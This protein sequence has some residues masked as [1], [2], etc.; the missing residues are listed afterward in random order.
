MIKE[1]KRLEAMKRFQEVLQSD[2][3]NYLANNYLAG[4]YLLQRQWDQAYSHLS[5]MLEKNPDAFETNFLTANFYYYRR[6]YKEALRFG[7]KAFSIQPGDVSSKRMND[8]RS[9]S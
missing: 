6:Q 7:Q 5:R 9:E 2:P 8:A 4:M 3:D 1:G